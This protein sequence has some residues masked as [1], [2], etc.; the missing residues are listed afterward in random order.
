VTVGVMMGY[1][2]GRLA[3]SAMNRINLDNQ[4]I[5]S[6]FLLTWVFFIYAFTDALHGNGYLAVYIAGLIV[7]NN[8]MVH[9]KSIA[10]FFDGFTWLWQIVIFLTLGLLV[11]PKELL[12]VAAIGL[13]IGVFMIIFA[14][15]L[16][17]FLCLI[18]FPKI[19]ARAKVY[20]SWVGLRGAVPIIFATY[21]LIAKI[22]NADTIFNIVFFITILS[23]IVQGTTVPFMA[24]KLGLINSEEENK[25]DF[26]FEIPE[27]IKSAMSEVNIT[28]SAIE[29][30]NKLMDLSLPDKTLV[31]MVKRE[32][33]Y[34]V[35][36]GSTKLEVDDKL[37][38]ISD[39]D[40][41]LFKACKELGVRH[42]TIHKS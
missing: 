40:E 33:K 26:G 31:V 29:K 19:T 24:H 5:Y 30:G 32:D 38:I 34:F 9:K 6:V 20:V 11:N 7:G 15:P 8:K 27:E 16:A 36:R 28:Q 25:D 13:L 21:P 2:L 42:Y 35:P 37:L 22:P 1:L 17:V 4:S 41:E 10:N 14:R 18:P 23:L 39:N 3:V 12:P